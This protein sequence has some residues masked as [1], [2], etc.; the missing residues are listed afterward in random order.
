[1]LTVER[2]VKVLY[3]THTQLRQEDCI[4]AFKREYVIH[5]AQ[6]AASQLERALRDEK[7]GHLHRYFAGFGRRLPK[8]LAALP[9]ATVR[10]ELLDWTLPPLEELRACPLDSGPLI[11]FLV[12]CSIPTYFN[13]F[14]FEPMVESYLRFIK[15]LF[16]SGRQN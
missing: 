4:T 11:K 5:D 15:Q 8:S 7:A 13:Y 12:F 14:F 10:H 6:G 3:E 16:Q 9:L 2:F 1:M